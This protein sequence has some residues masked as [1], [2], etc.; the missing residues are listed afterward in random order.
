[1]TVKEVNP[2]FEDFLFDW[3]QKF[4]L[5]VGGYGSS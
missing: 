2:H 4:Q 1:M 5:L 3:N